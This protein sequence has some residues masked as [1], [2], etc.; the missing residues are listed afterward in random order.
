MR[1]LN[2]IFLLNIQNLIC[3]SVTNTCN[4]SISI[5]F[6][7]SSGNKLPI[8]SLKIYNYFLIAFC[9]ISFYSRWLYVTLQT[10][11]N[12]KVQGLAL[13]FFSGL[14]LGQG[15]FVCI[16]FVW[17]FFHFGGVGFGVWLFSSN[18]HLYCRSRFSFYF[19]FSAWGQQC[20]NFNN[21]IHTTN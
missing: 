3:V 7:K 21:R 18:H 12:F 4:C 10:H 5:K 14:Y 20:F 11:T 16:L 13:M 1:Y 8:H 9:F 6:F 17:S 15:L 2:K 19:K